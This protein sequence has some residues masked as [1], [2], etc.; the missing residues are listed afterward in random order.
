MANGN[1]EG[2]AGYSRR[3]FM[4]P[5]PRL[6]TWD[7]FNDHLEAQRLKRQADVL[8]ASPRRSANASRGIWP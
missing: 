4:V 5:I 8:R 6:A 3:N 1:A 7:A 2:L